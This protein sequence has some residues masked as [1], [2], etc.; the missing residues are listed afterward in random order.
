MIAAVT[1][2]HDKPFTGPAAWRGAEFA[3]AEPWIYRLPPAVVSEFDAAMRRASDSGRDVP[4][5]TRDDFPAPSFVRDAEALQRDLVSG[6]GFVV[7]TGLPIDSYTNR[8]ATLIYWGIATWL[9]AP[10]PQNAQDDYLFDVRDEGYN[11]HRDYGAAG[12]RISRTSSAIE[13]HTDSSACYA[14]YT[15]DIVSLLA[16]QTAK[17]GGMTAL[18]SAQAV[19]NILRDER[20]ECLRRLYEPYYFDRRAELRPGDSPTLYAPVFTCDD[21]LSIRFFRFNLIKGHETAGVPL[22]PSDLE[23]V[24]ALEQVCR[25]EELAVTFDMRRGDMQFVNNRSVLHSRTAFEDHAEPALRR[26]FL[27]LWLR[28]S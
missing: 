2:M 1:P 4:S 12:V 5:L 11:F 28:Y 21:A 6:R 24:E 3:G 7:I 10:M 17:S 22:A 25:R 8:E 15:P 20:P 9:G 13:F 27:R 19:H 16:L 26:H 23:A 18:V 14:G